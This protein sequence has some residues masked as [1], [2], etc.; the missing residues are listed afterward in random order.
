MKIPTLSKERFVKELTVMY[1][2]TLHKTVEKTR[3]FFFTSFTVTK[4]YTI[5]YLKRSYVEHKH[6]HE[7]HNPQFARS[8]AIKIPQLK[9]VTFCNKTLEEERIK[10]AILLGIQRIRL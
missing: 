8:A 1:I 10:A 6:L 9:L 5:C 3:V 4:L 7:N 2:G